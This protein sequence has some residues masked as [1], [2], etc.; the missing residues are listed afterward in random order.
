MQISYI[1][2][3]FFSLPCCVLHR[4]AFPVVSISAS[5]PRNTA[6]STSSSI[7]SKSGKLC[8]LRLT[9]QRRVS[10]D[11]R[12]RLASG[13]RPPRLTS[14]FAAGLK[15]FCVVAVV[16][17]QS[18]SLGGTLVH[19]FA[20]RS[21][22]AHGIRMSRV[23]AT[24]TKNLAV[25]SPRRSERGLRESAVSPAANLFPRSAAASPGGSLGQGR[26]PYS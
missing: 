1:Q 15:G 3:G 4:I 19:S 25:A 16:L 20:R 5:Y 22:P 14:H 8:L 6:S 11:R 12:L 10:C 21:A 7:E 18:R 2:A 13:V 23:A 9:V 24:R 26:S 17:A